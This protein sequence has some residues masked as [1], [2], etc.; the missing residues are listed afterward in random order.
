MERG[1]HRE[2]LGVGQ[3]NEPSDL[4]ASTPDALAE[5]VATLLRERVALKLRRVLSDSPAVAMFRGDG[6]NGNGRDPCGRRYPTLALSDERTEPVGGLS[7]RRRSDLRRA[8]RRANA[9]GELRFGFLRPQ[10]Q[11]VAA[12]L[13]VAFEVE[14]RSRKGRHGQALAHEP[15]L[16]ALFVTYAEAAAANE[17]MRVE[18]AHRRRCGGDEHE[19]RV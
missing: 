16:A 2:L 3:L 17:A 15:S 18:S 14:A 9:F 6:Q 11:D 5:L 4:L 7:G 19:H 13:A 8:R 1:A 12:L 10:P